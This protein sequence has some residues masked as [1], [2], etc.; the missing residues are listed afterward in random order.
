M[1][2]TGYFYII[3]YPKYNIEY[4]KM[5]HIKIIGKMYVLSMLLL[6]LE[7]LLI[8]YFCFL[9]NLLLST[10]N[11]ISTSAPLIARSIAFRGLVL[12][13]YCILYILNVSIAFY[14]IFIALMKDSFLKYCTYF[15]NFILRTEFM[16]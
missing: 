5:Q 16:I 11:P 1:R 12:F 3:R 2:K 7:I 9:Y 6:M 8:S 4:I 14:I 13:C 10:I 15:F